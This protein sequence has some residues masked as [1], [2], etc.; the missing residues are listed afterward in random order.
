MQT[1]WLLDVTMNVGA[2]ICLGAIITHIVLIEWFHRI[3]REFISMETPG[4]KG[5][6]PAYL[7]VVG[8]LGAMT[9]AIARLISLCL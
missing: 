1:H 6:A 5:S 4:W 2:L 9:T 3:R 8:I 7:M